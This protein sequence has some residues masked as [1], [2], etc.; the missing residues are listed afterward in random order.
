MK[1]WIDQE[2]CTGSGLCELIEPE[3][4][5]LGEDGLAQVRQDG[6]ALPP[7]PEGKALVPAEYEDT[8]LEAQRGCPG[9]CIE[10]SD[11]D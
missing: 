4:F 10:I 7:G 1:V 11:E 8:V 2:R 5:L 3:V 9:G 6:R